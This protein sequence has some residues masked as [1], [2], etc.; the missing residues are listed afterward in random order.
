MRC[1]SITKFKLLLM[2][3]VLSIF[4]NILYFMIENYHCKSLKH[5]ILWNN[6]KQ[7]IEIISKLE[8][9]VKSVHPLPWN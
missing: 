2:Q 3:T 5:S 9:L 8:N 7:L 4:A 6:H 1:T